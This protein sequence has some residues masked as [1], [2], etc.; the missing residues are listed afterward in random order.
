M[1][2]K[3]IYKKV[4]QLSVNEEMINIPQNHYTGEVVTIVLK[5]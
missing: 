4:A 2:N 3:Q 1:E 5:Y